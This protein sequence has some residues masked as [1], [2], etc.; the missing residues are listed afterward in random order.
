[1]CDQDDERTCFSQCKN[2]NDKYYGGKWGEC[3]G[4]HLSSPEQDQCISD[5]RLSCCKWEEE[6]IESKEDVETPPP[7][8]D[9]TP[10]PT[11]DPTR[12]PTPGPT[13]L[14]SESKSAPAPVCTT[15]MAVSSILVI[16]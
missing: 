9:P 7:T 13:P 15:D 10:G 11:P 14:A 1:M 8:R 3:N 4:D 12:D 16:C 2:G 5:C 6:S